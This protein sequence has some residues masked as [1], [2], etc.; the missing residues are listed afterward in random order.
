MATTAGDLPCKKVF[1]AIGP[2]YTKNGY[3]CPVIFRQTVA[4]CLKLAT[5]MK[6]ESIA[7]PALCSGLYG[8]PVTISGRLLLEEILHFNQHDSKRTLKD[9]S[10]V[11]IVPKRVAL[12]EKVFDKRDFEADGIPK[13]VIADQE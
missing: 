3:E 13:A 1:H 12:L 6:Y 11:E 5:I 7:F 9:I 8:F 2:V 10:V 4:N